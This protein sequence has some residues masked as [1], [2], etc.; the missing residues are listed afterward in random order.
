MLKRLAEIFSSF[1]SSLFGGNKKPTSPTP[2]PVTDNAFVEDS[3]DVPTDTVIVVD[4]MDVDIP[5]VDNDPGPFADDDK[6]TAT[7]DPSH[8]PEPTGGGGSPTS[9]T[10]P[11]SGDSGSPTSDDAS[12]PSDPPP[13]THKQRFL[14]CLDN[15]HGKLQAGKRSPIWEEEDGSKM[16]FF[17][18]EFNRDVVERIIKKLKKKRRSL[19]RCRS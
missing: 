11:T 6:E 18:Y 1:F 2:R 16:Q 4:V 5:V 19:F 14:W 8:Q 3:S 13:P 7:D 12:E 15:G 9:D 10:S 17:E